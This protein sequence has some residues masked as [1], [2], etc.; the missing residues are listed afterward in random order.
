VRLA[1]LDEYR[2]VRP[3]SPCESPDGPS[4]EGRDQSFGDAVYRRVGVPA[5]SI[6][7]IRGSCKNAMSAVHSYPRAVDP[8]S[9]QPC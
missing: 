3:A 9:V 4:H 1:Q 5:P 7:C 6:S 8:R 2:H